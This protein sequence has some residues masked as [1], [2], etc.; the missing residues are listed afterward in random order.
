M[1]ELDLSTIAGRSIRGILALSVRTLFIQVISLV[2]QFILTLKIDP[3][4][5]GVF[6]I[7]SAV[8]SFLTYFSDI[9]LAAALIQKKGE[10]TE[11]DLKTT[12]TIQ[13]VLVITVVLVALLLSHT[14][15]WFYHLDKPGTLL[16][17]ALVVSFFFSSLKTIPSVL[18][19]RKLDFNKLVIPQIAETL[20]YSLVSVTLVLQGFGVTSFTFAVLARGI[21]G[22][23]VMYSV[24]PWKPAL[25]IEMKSAKKLLSFGF[26]FQTNSILAL[27]KDDLLIVALGRIL[28]RGEIGYVFGFSQKWAYTPLRLVLDNVVRITFPSYS[29]LQ[30]KK[31]SIRIA[32]EKSLFMIMAVVSPLLV[33]LNVLVAPALVHFIPKYARWE[34]ALLSLA[35]FSGNAI[36]SS[37]STPLTNFLN[38]IGKINITLRL[39]VFWT[40]TTWI[41]TIVGIGLFK[42]NGVSIA[43]FIVSLSVVIV[44]HLAKKYADFSIYKP[45]VPP[46]LASVA[47][48]IALYLITPLFVTNIP[49]LIAGIFFGGIVYLFVLY[50]IAHEEIQRD[51]MTVKRHLKNRT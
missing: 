44:V 25:G 45:I 33:G 34:P 5:L 28:T 32:L 24:A 50:A 49:T 47:M 10:I 12:F 22:L 15:S 2:S 23:I 42:F 14:V 16:F 37:I 3:S 27:L 41:A 20:V 40:A 11:D 51:I 17:Q 39:M 26:P 30:D 36:L 1:A 18:L 4:A 19:E 9:G 8:I 31:E 13:Q 43:S 6:A 38:A 46:L 21:I 35:F 7:V 48:G 29:R